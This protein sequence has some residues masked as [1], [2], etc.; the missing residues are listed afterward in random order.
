MKVMGCTHGYYAGIKAEGGIRRVHSLILSYGSRVT[1]WTK[2]VKDLSG[3][4]LG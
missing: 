4:R 1:I 2:L 3:E